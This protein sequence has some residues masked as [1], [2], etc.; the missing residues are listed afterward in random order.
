[1]IGRKRETF[2]QKTERWH[3]AQKLKDVVS[4]GCCDP[5][6]FNP[7]PILQQ[8]SINILFFQN[9]LKTQSTNRFSKSGLSIVSNVSFSI[10]FVVN[11]QNVLS[12]DSHCLDQ[13][14]LNICCC[15][16]QISSTKFPRCFNRSSQQMYLN[17]FFNR[18]SQQMF[19]NR[20]F[21]ADFSSTEFSST[22]CSQQISIGFSTF[23]QQIV[24]T[25]S[26][27]VLNKVSQHL[28]SISQHFST[29]SHQ[30]FLNIFLQKF[31]NNK[32]RMGNAERGKEKR[33]Q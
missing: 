22:K 10:G 20:F 15:P 19:L 18:F 32:I 33:N 28:L 16:N 13:R 1:M 23:S 11:L 30:K 29:F 24:S 25:F 5:T 21:S 6:V 27:H 3:G 12:N 31:L 7:L 17:R 8:T 9:K 2:Q 4:L 26:Q 14:F